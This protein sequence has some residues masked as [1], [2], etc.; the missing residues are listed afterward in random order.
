MNLERRNAL[1]VISQGYTGTVSASQ[2]K[3]SIAGVMAEGFT[4][5]FTVTA[6]SVVIAGI[7]SLLARNWF[8]LAPDLPN[9]LRQRH[10]G[11][12]RIEASA[13]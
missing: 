10:Y 4:L 2:G 8:S 6:G 9:K 5:S 7:P 1:I 13:R 12:S 3:C 11:S